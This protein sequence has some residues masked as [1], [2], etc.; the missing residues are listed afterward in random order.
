MIL[1]EQFECL[2]P[3]DGA[4]KSTIIYC[5]SNASNAADIWVAVGT[6]ASAVAAVGFGIASAIGAKRERN[7]AIQAER[8]L[9]LQAP[10]QKI[11]DSF[12]NLANANRLSHAVIPAG[13]ADIHPYRDLLNREGA[14]EQEFGSALGSLAVSTI[15]KLSSQVPLSDDGELS[16]ASLPIGP[17]QSIV[18]RQAAGVIRQGVTDMLYAENEAS[19]EE[20]LNRF[21]ANA[22][23]S[24]KDIEG[25]GNWRV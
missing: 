21:K 1:A 11:I 24:A 12:E 8:R 16:D 13:N 17:I 3:S 19:K 6:L 20:A 18:L 2:V 25:L 4:V 22:E 14:I 5:S 10:G 9:R 15:M 7:R 23:K